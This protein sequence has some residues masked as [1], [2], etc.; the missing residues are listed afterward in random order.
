MTIRHRL[1]RLERLAMP[2]KRTTYRVYMP[3]VT[4]TEEEIEASLRK[5]EARGESVFRVRF[6]SPRDE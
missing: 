4:G 5:A 1:N 6:P 3:G 2:E